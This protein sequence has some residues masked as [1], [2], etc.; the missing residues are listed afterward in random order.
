MALLISVLSAC[1]GQVKNQQSIANNQQPTFQSPLTPGAE[2]AE[3][4]SSTP[5]EASTPT[6]ETVEEPDEGPPAILTEAP[7][8]EQAETTA[9]APPENRTEAPA[10]ETAEPAT[11][12]P[13]GPLAGAATEEAAEAPEEMAAETESGGSDIADSLKDEL[14]F[15]V[16]GFDAARC[17]LLATPEGIAIPGASSFLQRLCLWG[18]PFYEPIDIRLTAL[19]GVDR[20]DAASDPVGRVFEATYTTVDDSSGFVWSTRLNPP[21][22][23]DRDVTSWAGVDDAGTTFIQ[24]DLVWPIDLPAGEWLAEATSPS[25]SAQTVVEVTRASTETISVVPSGGSN[26]FKPVCEDNAYSDGEQINVLGANFP[27]GQDVALGV[28][29]D[30]PDQQGIQLVYA[31]PLTAGGDGEFSTNLFFEPADP[32][33]EYLAIATSDPENAFHMTVSGGFTFR[34]AMACFMKTER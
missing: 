34:G 27:P 25:A 24:V 11:D 3:E 2:P 6:E 19:D 32:P 10:T 12:E 13:A 16:A 22:P 17:S 31:A 28:Y 23:P 7:P 4:L 14:Y 8:S 9:E 26:P 21:A 33:G 29:Y 18:F 5:A 30:S 20:A 15:G 1:R